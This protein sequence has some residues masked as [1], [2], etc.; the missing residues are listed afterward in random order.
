MR[1]VS[2]GLIGGLLSVGAPLGLLVLR[3]ARRRTW[4]LSLRRS[5]E[6]A[7]ND[8]GVYMYVGLSTA[9]VLTALGVMLGRRADQLA[10]LT[11]TDELTG[12]HNARGLSRRLNEEVDRFSRY[13]EPLALLLLDV[14]GLKRINDRFGHSAGNLV[15]Q[16][17]AAAMRAE[18]RA[19][20]VAARWGGDEFAILALNVSKLS[21][22]SLADKVRSLIAGVS[23]PWRST[24]SIGVVTTD[25]A[26]IQKRLAAAAM[27]DV[28]DAALYEAKRRGGN[29]VVV[30]D[31]SQPVL[32][33]RRVPPV[34]QPTLTFHWDTSPSRTSTS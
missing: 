10:E 16:H 2:Y 12:L 29:N 32:L 1:S 24:V 34:G 14:D 8:L 17:V 4:S 18:L 6:A 19:S 5:A 13:R 33:T 21:A 25:S 23:G 30:R 9:V 31:S 22:L 28:A 3:L 15:L 11:E 26:H 27:M 20:D 7:R